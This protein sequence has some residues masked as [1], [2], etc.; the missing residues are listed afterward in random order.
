MYGRRGKCYTST[1]KILVIEILF[2]F[3]KKVVYLQT[4]YKNTFVIVIY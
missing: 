4:D 1:K 3:Q 2:Y